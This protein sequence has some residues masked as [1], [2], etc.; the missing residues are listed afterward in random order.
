[1]KKLSLIILLIA[2]LL[3]LCA[4]GKDDEPAIPDV[5]KLGVLEERALPEFTAEDSLRMIN[6]MNSNRALVSDDTLYCLDFDQDY[7]PLLSAYTIGDGLTDRRVLA[8]GCIPECLS[9]YQGRLYYINAY[10]GDCIE[11][12]GT[13]GA[14]RLTLRDRAASYLQLE[15]GAM[16]Y[17]DMEG[18]FCRAELDGSGESLV[19]DEPCF[20]PFLIGQAVL[21][22]QGESEKLH[23]R[24][25]EDGTDVLLTDHA[26]YAPVIY[27][28]RLYYSSQ[29]TVHSMGLDGR[30]P[31]EYD[32]PG[33]EGAAE[34]FVRDG[35]LVLR[36]VANEN[37][38]RQWT[39]R[40][41][42][43][44]SSL[45]YVQYR[46]YR[47][48]SFAGDGLWADSV[49]NPDGRIRALVFTDAQGNETEYFSSL[50]LIE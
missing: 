1:M 50:G 26:A 24:Y 13:D 41:E 36:A 4:C 22:Q 44:Q 40:P 20:Y 37:G 8:E 35:Q 33:I 14:D 9:E 29:G 46:G 17:C 10:S 31:R 45:E 43:I 7:Q 21:Y 2:C 38:P 34:F 39:A 27:E 11:S 12:I 23:L 42:D 28:D 30:S 16:Y 15:G 3:C 18:R 19:I 5:E 49:Y 48:C 6:L 25:L 32:L 47:L